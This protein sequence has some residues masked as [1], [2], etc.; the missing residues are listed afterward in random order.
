MYMSPG[1]NATVT[2]SDL[3]ESGRLAWASNIS[4]QS[5][6]TFAGELT[7]LAYDHILGTCL[8]CERDKVFP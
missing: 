1:P 4:E 5:T 2:F 6:T 8:V 3:P 7:C